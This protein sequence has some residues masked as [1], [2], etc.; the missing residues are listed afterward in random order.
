MLLGTIPLFGGWG[1]SNW[2]NAWASE[3]GGSSKSDDPA[4][5]ARALLARSAPGSVASLLGGTLCL[6][7]GTSRMLL[8]PCS[9]MLGLFSVSVPPFTSIERFLHLVDGCFGSIQRFLLWVASV[10][11]PELFPTRVRATGAGVSFNFGRIATAVGILAVASMLKATFGG[12][13]AAMASSL[14]GS[15]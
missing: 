2:A 14:V 15:I 11:L 7:H 5:K 4:L 13:Y 3:V 9:W 12:D 10:C 6:S 1:S 8:S